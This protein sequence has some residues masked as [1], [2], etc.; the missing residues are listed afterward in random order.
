MNVFEN[1][2]IKSTAWFIHLNLLKVFRAVKQSEKI[3]QTIRITLKLWKFF[4]D[5]F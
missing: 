4:L 2:K 5:I 1:V 3:D